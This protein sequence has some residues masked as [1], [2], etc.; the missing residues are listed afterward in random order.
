MT[1]TTSATDSSADL[2]VDAR[3][4]TKSFGRT[5]ALAGLDLQVARGEVHGFLGPNGAGKTT[6]LRVL[7]GLLRIDGGEVRVLGGDPWRDVTTLHRRLAY[8]PGDVSLWPNL[9]GGEVIDLLSRLQGG[10]DAR[11][12][13][14]VPRA[15]RPRPD[16]EVPG[17]LPGQP[18]EG[19]ADLGPGDRRRPLPPRRAHRRTGPGQGGGVPGL[20]ARA[21][22]RRPDGPVEQP[23]P[24]RGGGPVGPGEH[25][26]GRTGR[27]DRSPGPAPAPDPDLGHRR[28]HDAAAGPRPDRRRP[29]PGR[30]GPPGHRP[31]RGRRHGRPHARPEWRGDPEPDQPAARASRSCSSATTGSGPT[32]HAPMPDTLAGTGPLLRLAL[33]RDR[34]LLSAWTLGFA[35]MA[36]LLG[37]GDRRPLPRRRRPGHGGRRGQRHPVPG[38]PLRTDL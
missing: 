15:L 33:R 34:W 35:A 29:R 27:G 23:H 30:R 6:T 18:P 13:R 8:V 26:P 11:A 16:Q 21:A 36:G 4:L 2:V 5:V 7:L 17:V 25:H 22:R 20:R 24:E 3:G 14:P 9:S 12:A 28:G 19:G 32:A 37:V 38:R 10:H 1:D 31:G